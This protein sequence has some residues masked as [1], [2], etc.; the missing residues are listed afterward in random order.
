M[1]HKIWP[2]LV[3]YILGAH[4]FDDGHNTIKVWFPGKII[5]CLPQQQVCS[6]DL[7]RRAEGQRVCEVTFTLTSIEQ[8]S[9]KHKGAA[10][11]LDGYW[12]SL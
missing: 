2:S 3:M 7:T 9:A 11:W 12:K 10:P 5:L 4:T 1:N 6:E 8:V